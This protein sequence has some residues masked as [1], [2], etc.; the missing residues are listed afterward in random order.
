[1]TVLD[2]EVGQLLGLCRRA[3]RL[4]A[5]DWAVRTALGRR[6]AGAVIVATDAGEAT[7]RRFA[8]LCRTARVPLFRH[9]TRTE[10]GQALGLE[11]KAVVAVT[12]PGLT[13]R[14]LAALARA[15]VAPDPHTAPDPGKWGDR[16]GT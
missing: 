5:G 6:T 4:A 3:G 9:G 14:V 2:R 7:A 11:G 8:G 12:D 15:G 16:G 13:D 1:M 10:L